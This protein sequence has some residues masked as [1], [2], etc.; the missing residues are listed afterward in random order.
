MN[1]VQMIMMIPIIILTSKLLFQ[2]YK[3]YKI[4]YYT[5]NIKYNISYNSSFNSEYNSS[6]NL[7]SKYISRQYI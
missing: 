5:T 2:S 6:F 3:N 4:K 1:I 7:A